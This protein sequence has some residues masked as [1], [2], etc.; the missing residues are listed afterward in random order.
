[1]SSSSLQMTTRLTSLQQIESLTEINGVPIDEIE[2]RARPHIR[3]QSGDF[4]FSE[5]GFLGTNDRFKDVLRKDWETVEALGTTHLELSVH[6]S[7]IARWPG[8]SY[9]ILASK[10]PTLLPLCQKHKLNGKLWAAVTGVA[11]IMG[12]LALQHFKHRHLFI[13]A[14]LVNAVWF[15]VAR[16]QRQPGF[17]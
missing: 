13:V 15:F 2:R 14:G 17:I 11:S 12:F 5:D 1:M 6:L 4:D 8:F 3:G 9:S 10:N 7:N 16:S